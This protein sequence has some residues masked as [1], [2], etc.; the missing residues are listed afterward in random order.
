MSAMVVVQTKRRPEMDHQLHPPS[1]SFHQPSSSN[2]EESFR[3]MISGKVEDGKHTTP[4]RCKEILEDIMKML[5]HLTSDVEKYNIAFRD[6][7]PPFYMQ[8]FQRLTDRID[9]LTKAR[10]TLTE[11]LHDSQNHL[12]FSHN[13]NYNANNNNNN[14]NNSNHNAPYHNYSSNLITVVDIQPPSLTHFPVNDDIITTRISNA[15][16]VNPKSIIIDPPP[17][18]KYSTSNTQDISHDNDVVHQ[19][20]P[21]HYPNLR[22]SSNATTS[23][24][25]NILP[26]PPSQTR[27]RSPSMT[28]NNFI[29]VHFPNKHTTA[30]APRND[31]TL[32]KALELKA[33]MHSVTN[34]R[35]Y[36][37]VYMISRQTCSWDII[38]ENVLEKEII[39][40]E[41]KKLDHSFVSKIIV[42]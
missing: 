20:S 35:A 14:N 40:E 34:L 37:P 21:Q 8:E 33:T 23:S 17:S 3:R 12:P 6:S 26:T 24:T 2:Q 25:S 41:K 22:T 30:L 32:E 28:P 13:E 36:I 18:S 38:L 31:Q 42:N 29:R 19:Q 39:L 11:Y 9:I 1:T 27:S 4:E 7:R 5:K 16:I 15:N 10:D